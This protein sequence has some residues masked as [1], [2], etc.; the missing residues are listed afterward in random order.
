MNRTAYTYLMEEMKTPKT[1]DFGPKG[2]KE[3]QIK[4]EELD[5]N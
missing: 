3:M 4:R 2:P 5:I 1:R